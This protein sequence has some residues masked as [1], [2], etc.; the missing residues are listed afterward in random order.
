MRA[1]DL[2]QRITFQSKSIS[3]DAIGGEVVTWV[4]AATVWAQALPGQ[5]GTDEEIA[6]DQHKAADV[7]IFRVRYSS[8]INTTWRISWGGALYDILSV[9]SPDAAAVVSEIRARAGISNG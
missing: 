9:H 2:N 3:R 7:T 6:N 8:L 4:D 5:P 1:G